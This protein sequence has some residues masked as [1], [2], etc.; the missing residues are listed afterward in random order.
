M[1]AY[2]DGWLGKDSPEVGNG[3]FINSPSV[4]DPEGGFA[5]AGHHTIQLL[6]GW[7][8]ESFEKWDSLKPDQRGE[9]YEKYKNR[10]SN[11]LVKAAE[12][13]VK[14]VSSHISFIKCIT[15]LDCKERV[16]AVRGGIYGS[17]HLP[18]Q[19][20]PGRFQNLSCGVNGLFL[21]GAGTFGCGLLY[22]TASGYLA[23][24]KSDL[25]LNQ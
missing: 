20:G 13:H 14:G 5:P 4:R 17:A 25:F 12:R 15:P 21:A 24:E 10:I 3:F 23:A 8:Y 18:S 11:S 7:S 6:S 22:C 19:M 2:Y 9:D 16:R 1:T